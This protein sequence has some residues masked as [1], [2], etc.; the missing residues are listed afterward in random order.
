[1]PDDG[2]DETQQ[3]LQIGELERLGVTAPGDV[4]ED[5]AMHS[6]QQQLADRGVES[7][8]AEIRRIVREARARR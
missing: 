2:T 7:D 8:A 5:E 6:V 3:R 1:M 4:D